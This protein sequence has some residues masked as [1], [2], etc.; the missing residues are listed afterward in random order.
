MCKLSTAESFG[1]NL[2][3][4]RR[5]IQLKTI[6]SPSHQ[7]MLKFSEIKF[8]IPSKVSL[9]IIYVRSKSLSLLVSLS[10]QFKTLSIDDK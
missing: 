5:N 8:E 4:I 2:H 6:F 3:E 1:G 9:Q 7:N 10:K